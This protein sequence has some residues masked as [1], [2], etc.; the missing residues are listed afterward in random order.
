MHSNENEPVNAVISDLNSHIVE[1]ACDK[2]S[3]SGYK[4]F[5]RHPNATQSKCEENTSITSIGTS[6]IPVLNSNTRHAKCTSWTGS[7]GSKNI[8]SKSLN[9]S[10]SSSNKIMTQQGESGT[11]VVNNIQTVNYSDE[12][13]NAIAD[14]AHKLDLSDL[15]PG[16]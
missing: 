3:I 14:T 13:N 11:D 8:T 7:E 9:P 1:S 15:T 10:A 12:A 16:E 5:N 2:S 6:K 4:V